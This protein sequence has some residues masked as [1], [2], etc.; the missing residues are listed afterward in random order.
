MSEEACDEKC[1]VFSRITGYL[2]PL[3]NWNEGKKSEYNERKTYNVKKTQE[4]EF[5]RAH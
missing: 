3:S 5:K 2:R 1:E 4:K